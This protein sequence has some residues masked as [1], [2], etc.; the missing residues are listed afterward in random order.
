MDNNVKN[1]IYKII[2]KLSDNAEISCTNPLGAITIPL[3][4]YYMAMGALETMY[5]LL[6]GNGETD[7]EN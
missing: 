2:N 4:D 1:L 3:E 7:E 5:E 6:N